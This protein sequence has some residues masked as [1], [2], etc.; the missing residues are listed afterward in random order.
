VKLTN[1][2]TAFD[3]EESLKTKSSLGYGALVSSHLKKLVVKNIFDKL[4]L[5][6]ISEHLVYCAFSNIK[7]PFWRCIKLSYL[8]Y[9]LN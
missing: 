7:L 3:L 8:L 6:C 9:L 1:I 5:Q 4:K 2:R